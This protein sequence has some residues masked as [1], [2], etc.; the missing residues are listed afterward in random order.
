MVDALD[1]KSSSKRVW[2]RV[3]Q[4]V[5]HKTLTFLQ[6][7]SVFAFLLPLFA[8]KGVFVLL[9]VILLYMFCV[10]IN[11]SKSWVKPKHCGI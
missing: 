4:P 8:L 5:L 1:S 7:V 6:K 11:E 10:V 2:V 9:F 3:P